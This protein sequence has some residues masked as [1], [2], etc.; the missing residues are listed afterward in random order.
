ML[1][2]KF[3]VCLDLP[4][5]ENLPTSHAANFHLTGGARSRNAFRQ[6]FRTAITLD[7]TTVMEA[8]L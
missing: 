3:S 7:G 1:A 8:A 2:W 6:V 5:P 4:D